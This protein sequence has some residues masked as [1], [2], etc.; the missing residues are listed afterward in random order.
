VPNL[1]ENLALVYAWA[2]EPDLALETLYP[3]VKIP[4]GVHYGELTLDPGWNPLR[5]DP[6][7]SKLLTELAPKD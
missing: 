6:R 2:N 1:V 4:S 7:F 5:K 3:I